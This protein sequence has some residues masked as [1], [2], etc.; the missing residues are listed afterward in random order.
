MQYVDPGGVWA[1]Y[2]DDASKVEMRYE[3][4]A[5]ARVVVVMMAPGKAML[6]SRA[7]AQDPLTELPGTI[8]LK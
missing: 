5:M 6:K 7:S 3:L 2:T 4:S 8:K 1:W